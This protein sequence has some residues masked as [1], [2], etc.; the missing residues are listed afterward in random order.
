MMHFTHLH[1]LLLAICCCLTLASSS[2]SEL[3]RVP[4]DFMS[5]RCLECHQGDHAEGD[6]DLAALLQAT[7]EHLPPKLIPQ[8]LTEKWVKVEQ[9]ILQKRMPPPAEDALTPDQISEKLDGI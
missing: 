5:Q 4:R 3:D 6:L 9:A 8:A 2:A 7:A 1:N